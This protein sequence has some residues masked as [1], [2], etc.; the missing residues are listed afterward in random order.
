M[1]TQTRPAVIDR[2]EPWADTR[3]WLERVDAIGE[4]RVVRG[5]DWQAGIAEVTEMLDH[6]DGSPA[7]LFDDVP[8][9]PSGYRVLVN[10]NGTPR[11]QAV[12][13]ALSDASGTHEGMR[14]FWRG[15]LRGS[16]RA[17]ATVGSRRA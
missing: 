11:R 10:A 17:A 2:M 13:L 5:V 16:S 6:T 9:Y 12:T 14:N 7:V 8:G 1:V 15:V 4:L 3:E